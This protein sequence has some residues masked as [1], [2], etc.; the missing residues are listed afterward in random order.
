MIFKKS[1]T[2]VFAGFI[3]C[4]VPFTLPS[5]THDPVGIEL[6]DSVYFDPTILGI[7]QPSC[8][9][10]GTMACH[11]EWTGDFN[12]NDHSSIIAL[13]Y[14]PGNPKDS[15]LYQVITDINGENFMPPDQPLSKENR[16]LI[17]VWIAQGAKQNKKPT[18]PADTT[19]GGGGG[20]L[21][22]CNDS[23]YFQQNVFPIIVNRCDSCHNGTFQS[24]EDELISLTN[25]QEIKSNINGIINAISGAREDP[26]PPDK[27]LKS[28]DKT[29]IIKWFNEGAKNNSCSNLTCDT[30][31]TVTYS[32]QV[33]PIIQLYCVKCH[34]APTATNYNVDLSSPD[35]V[36]QVAQTMVASPANGTV[37][38]LVG[39][40]EGMQGF[41]PMPKGN[42]LDQCSKRTLELWIKQKLQ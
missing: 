27:P 6:L 37:S 17:E 26:M 28:Q 8:G 41:K 2:F 10:H 38:R 12:I 35:K 9:A 32:K 23:A 1:L 40:I 39:V 21:K 33:D 31:N 25:Y 3:F 11:S 20:T 42:S 16:T 29:M 36:R 34:L 4:L 13:A 22:D 19:G 30:A 7:I 15:K 14:T 5:C 24:G 18:V